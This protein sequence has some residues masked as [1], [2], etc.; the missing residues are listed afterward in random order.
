LN[1]QTTDLQTV[2]EQTP[3][4][5]MTDVTPSGESGIVVETSRDKIH[6]IH[7]CGVKF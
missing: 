2:E 4:S 3:D 5:Q 6:K 1:S 7:K